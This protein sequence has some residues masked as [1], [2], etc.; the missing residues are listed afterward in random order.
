LT[1]A[2]QS[3]RVEVEVQ[4]TMVDERSQQ[5]AKNILEQLN[6]L[7]QLGKLQGEE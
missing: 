1:L 3:V 5:L 2:I 7:V 6:E 4:P